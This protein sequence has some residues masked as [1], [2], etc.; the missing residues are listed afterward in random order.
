MRLST[1]QLLE[2]CHRAN[3]L[4]YTVLCRMQSKRQEVSAS[5]VRKRKSSILEL[6]RSTTQVMF[7]TSTYQ[8][9]HYTPWAPPSADGWSRAVLYW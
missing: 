3:N 5:L 2:K 9:L 8:D 4:V 7:L 1:N 6:G